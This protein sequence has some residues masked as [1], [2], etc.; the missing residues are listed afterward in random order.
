MM[1]VSHRD[2][3]IGS[4][5]SGSSG[6]SRSSIITIKNTYFFLLGLFSL[7]SFC[8][9]GAAGS[10]TSRVVPPTTVATTVTIR[11]W[12]LDEASPLA[13]PLAVVE[14]K[15]YR[16]NREGD[17]FKNDGGGVANA[18]LLSYTPPKLSSGASS[19]KKNKNKDKKGGVGS[20]DG[21]V[22]GTATTPLDL[23]R[24]GLYEDSSGSG[25][26]WTGVVVGRSGL[27][28]ALEDM[29]D[30][31][32]GKEI[33]TTLVLHV[34][35]DGVLYGVGVGAERVKKEQNNKKKKGGRGGGTV[36]EDNKP[37]VAVEVSRQT[38]GPRPHLNK[39]VT[40]SP[41]GKTKIMDGQ[42]PEKTFLQ[43]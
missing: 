15:Y 25:R 4:H 18:T 29:G 1:M 41:D 19:S 11:A 28:G 31:D 24:V 17:D 7:F 5:S 9:S 42:E 23:V 38:L 30:G 10:T 43:K 2:L 14:Y 12:P 33:K 13:V 3:D 6:G 40:V 16:G 34:N 37:N 27:A 22:T 35:T 36:D 32:D 21:D 20:R 39:L 8:V 26:Q